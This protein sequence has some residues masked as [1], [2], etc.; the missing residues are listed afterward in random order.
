PQPADQQESIEGCALVHLQDDLKDFTEVM[1]AI[2]HPFY[3]DNLSPD[4]DLRTLLAFVSGILNISTK[5]NLVFLRQKC[6]ALLRAK[7][8][9]TLS[10]AD[11]LVSSGF[12]YSAA[13]VVRFIPLARTAN[14]PA[15]LPWAFYVSTSID[16][17]MLIADPVLSWKDKALCL[18]GR[19]A[20][21][22]RQKEDTHRFLFEF[23][24]AP[25]CRS[26]CTPRGMPG[27]TGGN[28]KQVPHNGGQ[29]LSWRSVEQWRK[30]PAPLSEY[31]DWDT[32]GVCPACLGRVQAEHVK[33]RE[34][35]W[36]D[37]PKIFHLAESWDDIHSQQN[38]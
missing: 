3:F 25:E 18:A 7:F 11:S 34:S 16:P 30:T 26:V 22:E 17:E 29:G 1:K 23:S 32:L 8:P 35:V 28:L 37:L 33:G 2:Y 20:L 19:A 27:Y 5:Y 38:R 12:L 21:W 6:I 31:D 15:L 14:V 24:R 9:V 10:G 13:T 4:A 36:N